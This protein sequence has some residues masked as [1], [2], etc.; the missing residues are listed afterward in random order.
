MRKN[1]KDYVVQFDNFIP[2]N[3]CDD[4]IKYM[5]DINF[6]QHDFYNPTKKE[7]QTLIEKAQESNLPQLKDIIELDN[8]KLFSIELLIMKNANKKIST[9]DRHYPFGIGY[10]DRWLYDDC[11]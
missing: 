4:T 5:E 6:Q 8:Y 11:K 2:K 9:F 3:I 7:Y 10:N 1:L